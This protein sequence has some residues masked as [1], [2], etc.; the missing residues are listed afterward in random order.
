MGHYGVRDAVFV[1]HVSCEV[2]GP[3]DSLSSDADTPFN[4]TIHTV[5]VVFCM[6]VSVQG[7][8][9]LEDSKPGAI[10]GVAGKS[11]WSA[12]MGPTAGVT[13]TC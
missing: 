7:L 3:F 10:R 8:L 5:I 11:A 6:V 4:R 2:I 9:C 13:G 12:G 1:P